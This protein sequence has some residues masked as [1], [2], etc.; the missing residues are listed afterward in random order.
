I[1]MLAHD[2]P[3]RIPVLGNLMM[4]A[5]CLRATRENAEKVLASGASLLVYPG[6][7]VD[8]MRSFWNRN[9][10]DLRGHTGFI[11]LAFR[12]GVPI[13]PFVNVGGQEVYFTIFSGARLARWSGIDRLLRVKALPLIAGLPWGLWWTGFVPYLPLPSKLS[14]AVAPPIQVDRDPVSARDPAALRRVYRRVTGTMQAMV[15]EMASR[16]RF[17]VI[18]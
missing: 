10:V 12:Y 13:V 9:R 4:R 16:R 2:M 17:P 3:L 11:A 15:D 14:Y 8:C 5:G 6:G 7:D 1:Y 18:G